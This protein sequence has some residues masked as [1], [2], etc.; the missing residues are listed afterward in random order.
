MKQTRRN[1]IKT[2]ALATGSLLIPYFLKAIGNKNSELLRGISGN[3]KLVIIQLGGGNDGLNT[4]VPYRN[5]IYYSSRPTLAVPATNVLQLNDEL[6]MNPVMSSLADLYNRGQFSIINN[7][8]YPN[9]DRSHFRSMDIW[10]TASDSHEYLSTGWIGRYLDSDCSNCKNPHSAIELNDSLTLALKGE[11]LNGM[12]FNDEKSLMQMR[13]S[14]EMANPEIINEQIIN[15]NLHY[16]YKTLS[17]TR[18]SA[19]YIYNKSKI[20]STK[21]EYPQNKFGKDLKL[22]AE[23]IISDIE[24]SVFYV[25][26]S[27]FDT[28]F[29]QKGKQERLLKIYS[30]TVAVFCDD[31]TSNG[32]FDDTVIMTFSEFGRRVKQN[33]SAGTDHGTANNIFMM[34]GNIKK[35]GIY[36]DTPNLNS[37]DNGD[38]IYNI[39]FRSVY[40][41]LLNNWL[42]VDDQIILGKQ[43]Q[44]LDVL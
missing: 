8:G 23:L 15:S 16:L 31:L 42:Q 7:V 30:D 19:E 27:G 4:I 26:L 10:Q 18:N 20:Y 22:V 38:L 35:P 5:D 25:T 24:T 28:H 39:D 33:G 37:L 21:K 17:E 12:A 13:K 36:N 43:F 11:A 2:S 32:R 14:N 40:A 6:G 41:T 44:K 1:F 3:R 9:P 29:A 34:G